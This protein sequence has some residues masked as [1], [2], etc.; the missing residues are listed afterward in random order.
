MNNLNLI[1]IIFIYEEKKVNR[2]YNIGISDKFFFDEVYFK[3]GKC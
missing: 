2:I 1:I 3:E